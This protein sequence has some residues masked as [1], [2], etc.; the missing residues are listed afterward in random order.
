MTAGALAVPPCMAVLPAAPSVITKASRDAGT[1]LSGPFYVCR[2]AAGHEPADVHHDP[3]VGPGGVSWR[4]RPSQTTIVFGPVDYLTNEPSRAEEE[5]FRAGIAR[6]LGEAL[7]AIGASL[8]KVTAVAAIHV[9]A[10]DYG[11]TPD[12]PEALPAGHR[13]PT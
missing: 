5:S 8:G 7:Q 11:V 10:R 13:R 3:H 1:E 12:P 9:V 2:L 6:G 4:V